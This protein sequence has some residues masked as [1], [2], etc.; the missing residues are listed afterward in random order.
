M[1]GGSGTIR[2]RARLHVR[3]RVDLG[4]LK[5]IGVGSPGL[6]ISDGASSRAAAITFS[7]SPRLHWSWISCSGSPAK[8]P[9]DD[10]S[11]QG[12][13]KVAPFRHF[14]QRRKSTLP[15]VVE[16]TF[17]ARFSQVHQPNRSVVAVGPDRRIQHLDE[18]CR[19]DL[20]VLVGIERGIHPR[21]ASARIALPRTV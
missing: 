7:C 1:S 21:A 11:R 17:I 9:D 15:Q 16:C 4:K 12:M 19:R 8:R 13:R 18:P 20:D 3:G 10:V 14:N 5:R 6:K 2:S